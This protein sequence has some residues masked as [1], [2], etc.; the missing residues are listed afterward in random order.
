[1]IATIQTIVLTFIYLMAGHFLCD[2]ALQGDF[3]ARAKNHRNPI[4]GVPAWMVMLSHAWIQAAATGGVFLIA[5]HN[6]WF[7]I[8][9]FG[10]ELYAHWTMDRW[11]C[12]G[13][14]TYSQDQYGHAFCKLLYVFLAWQN[15][16]I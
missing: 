15:G 5:Y 1:M 6:K 3:M 11:K 16:V 9:I 10:A 12:E 2:Y 13:K 7:A 14:A 8:T 4:V